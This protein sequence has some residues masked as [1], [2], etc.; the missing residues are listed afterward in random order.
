MALVE[1]HGFPGPYKLWNIT[2]QTV[3]DAACSF[4]NGQSRYFL[5]YGSNPGS[6]HWKIHPPYNSH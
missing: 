5:T 6:V 3:S 4:V 1:W 2:I